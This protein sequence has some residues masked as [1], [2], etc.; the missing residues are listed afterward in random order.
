MALQ[1][2]MSAHNGLLRLAHEQVKALSNVDPIRVS[3]KG[4]FNIV[5]L[6]DGTSKYFDTVTEAADYYHFCDLQL[7]NNKVNSSDAI[8]LSSTRRAFMLAVDD[9]A[10]TQYVVCAYSPFDAQWH[11]SAPMDY[12]T[13]R[14][15]VEQHNR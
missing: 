2:I 5:N 10:D 6:A 1:I 4:I 11:E 12:A 15:T 8:R 14:A 13:A 3:T 9:R 7:T